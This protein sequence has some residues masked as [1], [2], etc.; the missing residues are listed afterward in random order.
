[1][2]ARDL[3]PRAFS[4]LAGWGAVPFTVN[5]HGWLTVYVMAPL[6]GAV[7]GGA[8]YRYALAPHY[9]RGRRG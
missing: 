2:E 7:C 9:A 4:S 1:M 5:G 3:G 6:I 8:V